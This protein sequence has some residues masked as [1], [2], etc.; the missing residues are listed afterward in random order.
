MWSLKKQLNKNKER[1][2]ARNKKNYEDF[3]KI[4]NRRRELLAAEGGS[5]NA[6]SE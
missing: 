4:V 5:R 6:Q 3:I 1:A 2:E